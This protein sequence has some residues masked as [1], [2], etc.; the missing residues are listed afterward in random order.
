MSQA[1]APHSN[2]AATPTKAMPFTM[3]LEPQEA[4]ALLAI[5]G[6]SRGSTLYPLY[7]ALED[8]HAANGIERKEV[9]EPHDIRGFN[10]DTLID[11]WTADEAQA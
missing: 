9:S 4:Q 10:E 6:L 8:F 2:A 5:V 1:H 11:W 7:A 3:R